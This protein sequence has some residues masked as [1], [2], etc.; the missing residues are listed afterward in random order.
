M[1]ITRNAINMNRIDGIL[2]TVTGYSYN[3]GTIKLKKFLTDK[4]LKDFTLY[5]ASVIGDEFV[6]AID[7]QRYKS[8]KWPP[9]S[10]RY[11]TW[12]KKHSLSLNMWEATGHL[13]N[14]IKVFKKGNFIAI[15]F[16]QKDYY[17]NTRLQVNKV[18]RFVEFGTNGS[19][20][21]NGLPPR[22]LFRPVLIHIRKHI[23]DYY[24]KYQK[25]LKSVSREY[26]YLK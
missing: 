26:L 14:E 13:K 1:K 17:P 21:R 9:L 6:R 18:A 5:M 3:P 15:G 25:E 4:Q 24:K 11:Y 16:R 7:T 10:V 23:D 22:P 8:S 19:N 20:G 12:K 2:I